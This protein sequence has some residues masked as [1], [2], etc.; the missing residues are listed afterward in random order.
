MNTENLK[1][2]VTNCYHDL[3]NREPDKSGLEYYLSILKNNKINA[4][5]FLTVI[6]VTTSQSSNKNSA[7]GNPN[8]KILMQAISIA[9]DLMISESS[10]FETSE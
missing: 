9:F 3:L 1:N 7:A 5:T 4:N 2:I 10:C 8:A 6:T